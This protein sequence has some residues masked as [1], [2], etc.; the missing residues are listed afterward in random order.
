MTPA[1][2]SY[3]AVANFMDRTLWV[4]GA[5]VV[6]HL[7]L[8]ALLGWGLLRHRLHVVT[9]A[10]RAVIPLAGAMVYHGGEHGWWWEEAHTFEGTEINLYPDGTVSVKPKQHA[11]TLYPPTSVARVLPL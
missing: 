2:A 8:V 3:D 6:A 5:L 1:D 7:V 4:L 9:E 11:E 10:Q